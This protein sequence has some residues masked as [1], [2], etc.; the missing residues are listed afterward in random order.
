LA[1]QNNSRS[2]QRT[3]ADRI[4]FQSGKAEFE[5][6]TFLWELQK[7]CYD[8]DMDCPDSLS[9]VLFVKAKVQVLQNFINDSRIRAKNNVV[10]THSY[11]QLAMCN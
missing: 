10:P 8:T 2:I 3:L 11:L 5:D 4:I 1:L 7:C 9:T 6:K